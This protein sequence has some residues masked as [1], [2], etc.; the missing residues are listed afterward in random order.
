MLPLAAALLSCDLFPATVTV[1]VVVPRTP[2]AWE[3]AWGPAHFTLS[4]RFAGGSEAHA[5]P[6]AAGERVHITLPRLPPVAL[7]AQAVWV[8]GGGPALEPGDRLATAGAV[9]PFDATSSGRRRCERSVSLSFACGPTAEVTWR[10]LEAGVDLRRFSADRLSAE[11]ADRLPADPWALDIERV[12]RAIGDGAMRVT[13]VRPVAT[14][15]VSLTVPPGI[16]FRASPFA[17]PVTG[18]AGMPPL[19]VGVTVLWASSHRRLVVDVD[20]R[21]RAW[22]AETVR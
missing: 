13:Y 17:E 7:R 6:V 15:E 9:W 3:A 22:L 16:W 12:V 10:L 2:P 21:G 19:P 18:D 4:W 5:A 1:P 20:E 14:K 8:E 11:I